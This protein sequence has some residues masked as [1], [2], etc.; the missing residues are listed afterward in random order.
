M[1]TEAERLLWH[2]PAALISINLQGVILAHSPVM[3]EWLSL[4][5]TRRSD[6]L[7]GRNLL[8]WLTPASRLLYETS[9][10]PRLLETGSA[11][12]VVMHARDHRG[13]VRPLLCNATL[14]EEP[15]GERRVYLA[16]IDAA[17]R[18][19]FERDLVEAQRSAEAARARLGLLQ[20]ATGQ[21]AVAKGLDDLGHTLADAAGRAAQA[22]WTLVRID[23][24]AQ[25][26]EAGP[27][28][29]ASHA[30]LTW[31]TWPGAPRRHGEGTLTSEALVCRTP[32]EIRAALPH[33]AEELLGNGVEALVVTPILR[34]DGDSARAIGAIHSWFRRS[35]A[36]DRD[37]LDTLHALAAQAELVVDHVRLQEGVRHR[38]LHDGLTGL[39]NRLLLQER[40]GQMLASARRSGSGCGVLFL[41]L[42]GFKPINDELGHQVGDE[43]LREVGERLLETCRAEE[44]VARLGGDEFVVALADARDANELAQ[45]ILDRIRAPLRGAAAGFRLSA[46]IGVALWDA[47]TSEHIPTPAEMVA[48]ADAAMYEAKRRGKDGIVHRIVVPAESSL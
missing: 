42:D 24:A 44:T 41:D 6:A 48:E 13:T 16:F 12:E 4:S 27:D 40:V 10:M 36:L 23:T 29:Q 34:A 45:R 14:V 11:R 32:E 39:P 22:P 1:Q 46:S 37:V 33:A 3:P 5:D 9:F 17:D 21:L 30:E 38:A 26:H 35:R 20:A 18:I 28:R 15:D 7:A 43:V 31:G 2:S 19:A 25:A 47:A 8:E